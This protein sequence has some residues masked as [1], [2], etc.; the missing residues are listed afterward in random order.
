MDRDQLELRFAEAERNVSLGHQL[1]AEQRVALAQLQ[2]WGQDAGAARRLLRAFEEMQE[3]HLDALETAV[4]QLA[5]DDA[6]N[7]PIAS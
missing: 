7:L 4:A 6:R 1:I 3:L 5:A 2:S